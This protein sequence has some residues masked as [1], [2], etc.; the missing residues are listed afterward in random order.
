MTKQEGLKAAANYMKAEANMK[1]EDNPTIKEIYYDNAMEW[2][3]L[4][5]IGYDS[6]KVHRWALGVG[7]DCMQ[8]TTRTIQLLRF[9]QLVIK[10][11]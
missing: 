8:D 7:N 4:L 5:K 1:K 11:K 10:G 3:Q 9:T 2:L 6:E